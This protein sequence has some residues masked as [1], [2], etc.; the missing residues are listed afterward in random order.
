LKLIA[1]IQLLETEKVQPTPKEIDRLFGIEVR[2]VSDFQ[3]LNGKLFKDKLID[4]FMNAPDL[5]QF[6]SNHSINKDTDSYRK[7][8]LDL[9]NDKFGN[10]LHHYKELDNPLLVM[11]KQTQVSYKTGGYFSFKKIWWPKFRSYLDYD[12]LIE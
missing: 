10:V 8:T 5:S 1:S 4:M 11:I 9:W 12:I 2:T 7:R 6:N 3:H